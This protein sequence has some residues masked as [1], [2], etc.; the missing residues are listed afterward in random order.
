MTDYVDSTFDYTTLPDDLEILR[1]QIV[2]AL[3]DIVADMD[4]YPDGDAR[5]ATDNKK[6]FLTVKPGTL[7]DIALIECPGC[8]IEESGEGIV[9]FADSNYGTTQ[10]ILRVLFNIKV[11]KGAGVDAEKMFNYYAARI[12]KQFVTSPHLHPA[13]LDVKEAGTSIQINGP[14]DPEP[15]GTLT[16]EVEYRH[17]Y[18]DP[19]TE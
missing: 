9:S 1:S 18:G 4:F 10:K 14:N 6:L 13:M 17:Q 2:D 16:L 3:T 11:V 19:F 7:D 5:Q 12:T 15:G 8:A